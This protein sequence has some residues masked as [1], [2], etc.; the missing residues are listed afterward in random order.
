MSDFSYQRLTAGIVLLLFFLVLTVL[1][2]ISWYLS[3]ND[4]DYLPTIIGTMGYVIFCCTW[5]PRMKMIVVWLFSLVR[6]SL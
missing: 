4:G 5:L 6:N 3:I 1:V 2:P